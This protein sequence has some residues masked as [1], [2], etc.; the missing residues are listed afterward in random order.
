MAWLLLKRRSPAGEGGE[1]VQK[2]RGT[3][4]EDRGTVA[5]RACENTTDREE[6][7]ERGH[8]WKLELVEVGHGVK[9]L[10][11]KYYY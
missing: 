7:G 3:V 10:S 11:T 4:Q 8:E 2:G 1:T 5:D 9:I 6:G